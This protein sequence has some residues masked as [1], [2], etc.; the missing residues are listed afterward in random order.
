M[1]FAKAIA[2]KIRAQGKERSTADAYIGWVK[3]YRDYCAARRIGKETRAEVA[4]ERFLSML[5]NPELA[6]VNR[7]QIAEPVRLRLYTG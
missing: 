3:R 5:A 6:K 4:V 1:D 7:E 2:E